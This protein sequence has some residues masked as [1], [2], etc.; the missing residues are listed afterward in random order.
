MQT[1]KSLRNDRQYSHCTRKF[2][3]AKTFRSNITKLNFI[4]TFQSEFPVL[5]SFTCKCKGHIT[6]LFI[7]KTEQVY[8]EIRERIIGERILD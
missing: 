5:L 8:G 7:T 6:L 3:E 2:E 1:Q 4:L